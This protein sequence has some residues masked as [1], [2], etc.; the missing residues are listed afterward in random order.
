[1]KAKPKVSGGGRVLLH[2]KGE[3]TNEITID[4]TT[5]A[6]RVRVK[7]VLDNGK[8]CSTTARSGGQP[9]PD[10]PLRTGVFQRFKAPAFVAALLLI[11]DTRSE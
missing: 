11:S 6:H 8:G 10:P 4:Q 1:V 7:A 3:V 2:R 5:I 9:L